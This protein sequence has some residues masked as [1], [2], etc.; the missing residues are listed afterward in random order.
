MTAEMIKFILMTLPILA[1]YFLCGSMERK[2]NSVIADNKRNSEVLL[3][4][5]NRINNLE[6]Q[7]H[8]LRDRLNKD[9]V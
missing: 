6:E 1:L 2:I 5:E 9:A 7:I 4:H 3:E 8:M